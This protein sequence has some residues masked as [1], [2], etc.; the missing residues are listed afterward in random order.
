MCLN[1]ACESFW[2]IDGTVAP[3]EQD[4]NPAFLK[5]RTVFDGFS[6]PYDQMPEPVIPKETYGKTFTATRQCWQGIVC[7][8]CG[9]CNLRRHWDAWRCKTKDCPFVLSLPIDPIAASSVS[10]DAGYGFQ[11]HGIASDSVSEPSIRV[12]A[13]KA[14]LFRETIYH[15]GDGVTI[16]HLSSNNAINGAPGG[17]DDLFLQLQKEH[18]GLERLPLKQSQ[19]QC[20]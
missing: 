6:P 14:G 2:S 17:P 13:K 4:Y 11:G 10:G 3:E 19:G 9:R 8:L 18:L 1:S 15:L 20:L 12:E 16:T 5:E 7:E